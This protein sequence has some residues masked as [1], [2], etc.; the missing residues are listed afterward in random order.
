MKIVN[1]AVSN[2]R[3]IRHADINL[4]SSKSLCCIIGSG[5]STKSTLLDAISWVFWPSYS[6]PATDLDFFDCCFSKPI[7]IEATVTNFP[8][9]MKSD[10]RF[11]MYL[12]SLPP[13][14]NGNDDPTDAET[15]ITVRLEIKA[16]LEP[17]WTVIKNS[18]NARSISASDRRELCVKCIGHSAGSRFTW[19]KNSLLHDYADSSKTLAS[20]SIS[21][22]RKLMKTSSFEDLDEIAESVSDA[23]ASFGVDIDS[24]SIHSKY[25]MHR[26]S[27]SSS[28]GLFEN[29][30]PLFQK[31]TGTQA[32]I[33]AALGIG[34]AKHGSVLLIDEVE[35]GLEPYRLRGL[36]RA[37]R[38]ELLRSSGQVIITTHSP[39]A[40]TETKIEEIYIAH[41]FD[42]ELALVPAASTDSQLTNEMQKLLRGSSEAFLAK[43][44][45]V[46]EGKTEA[47]FVRGI[48]H[49]KDFGFLSRNG[50]A[51]DDS[52]GGTQMFKHAFQWKSFGYDACILMDSDVPKNDSKKHDAAKKDI[53]IFDWSK[54]NNL[55]RQLFSDAPDSLIPQMIEVA[56]N[57]KGFDA[58]ARN[59]SECELDLSIVLKQANF[60]N[61]ERTLIGTSASENEWYKLIDPAE[62]LGR[63]IFSNISAFTETSK[64][65]CTLRKLDDWIQR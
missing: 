55:E 2:F 37:L 14:D 21:A 1:L 64:T 61:D 38:K 10:S 8:E 20:A 13:Y 46:C 36:I 28:V 49:A 52:N 58:I 16:D 30:I 50:V 65:A 47:G 17:K 27:M 57:H 4:S 26:G 31:G 11:G 43:K 23:A 40:L 3:G 39:V 56:I 63:I 42:G 59:L 5:D 60:S 54:G 19:G 45:I 29:D 41:N 22:A 24:T 53:A 25:F 33:S 34:A 35:T 32:L 48:E 9:E 18:K 15:C 44:I 51:I 62:D 7:V 12:R 6:I